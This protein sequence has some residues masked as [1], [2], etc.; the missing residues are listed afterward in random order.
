MS[1]KASVLVVEDDREIN[2]LVGA[3]AQLCGFEYRAALDGT[4]AL[5]EA[6]QRP[7]AAVVLDLMLPD[8]DG[9]EV[10]RRLRRDQRTHHTPIIIL[11]ALSDAKDRQLGRDCGADEYLTKP[12]DPDLLMKTL[13]EHVRREQ[14]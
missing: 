6:S 4:T 8:L 2:A 7:P 14:A 10:C 9:F 5:N 12:F 3:Y 1:S 13:S 11:T